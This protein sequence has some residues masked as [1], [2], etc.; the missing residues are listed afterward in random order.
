MELVSLC[1]LLK[2]MPDLVIGEDIVVIEDISY[3]F[4]TLAQRTVA[5]YHIYR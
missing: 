3:S 5:A 2:Q 1:L 4:N